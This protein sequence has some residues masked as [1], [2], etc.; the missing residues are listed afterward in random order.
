MQDDKYVSG[1]DYQAMRHNKPSRGGIS[2][3]IW[4]GIAIVV[5]GA[6]FGTFSYLKRPNTN[7]VSATNGLSSGSSFDTSGGGASS[8]CTNS[9]PCAAQSINGG[10]SE[11]TLATHAGTITAVSSS[12]ITIQL[13][14]SSG[15][16][17]FSITSSTQVFDATSNN[18]LSLSDIHTGELVHVNTA[19]SGGVQAV[20]VVVNPSTN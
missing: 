10:G 14:G 20:V 6:G 4:V 8:G 3:L 5:I 13:S 17:T 11:Q 2:P 12:S 1:E 7:N 19:G 18:F 15:T 16:E 9:E